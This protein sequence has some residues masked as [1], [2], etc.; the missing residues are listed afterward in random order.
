MKIK[1][2]LR[3]SQDEWEGQFPPGSEVAVATKRVGHN[4]A[5]GRKRCG[6]N[7]VNKIN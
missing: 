4:G 6:T 3:S 1:E 7:I 2:R 5:M